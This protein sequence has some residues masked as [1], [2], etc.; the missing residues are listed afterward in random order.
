MKGLRL[1]TRTDTDYFTHVGIDLTYE[2]IATQTQSYKH[3][4]NQTELE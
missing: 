4:Y 2:G 1:V 3:S